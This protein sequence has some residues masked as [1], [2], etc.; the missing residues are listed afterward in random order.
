MEQLKVGWL[1]KLGEKVRN[2]KRRYCVVT[3][4]MF[5]YFESPDDDQ[6]K[7]KGRITLLGGIVTSG[8]AL[9]EE[10]FNDS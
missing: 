5:Y 4:P 10:V 9:D 8:P 2:W 1:L 3:G 6:L 7:P